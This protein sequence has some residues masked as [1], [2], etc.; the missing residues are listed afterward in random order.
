MKTTHSPLPWKV[1]GDVY[2]SDGTKVA[3]IGKTENAQLIVHR[4]NT[5]DALVEALEL[6]LKDAEAVD[7][8]WNLEPS[9]YS[10][11]IQ[12]LRN[13]LALAGNTE[14]TPTL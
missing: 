2:S 13:A 4:V 5:Y 9:E 3:M 11:I 14:G 8:A 6:A 10:P 7:E 12:T 1:K